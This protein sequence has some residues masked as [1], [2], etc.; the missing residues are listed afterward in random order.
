LN[1]RILPKEGVPEIVIDGPPGSQRV[2]LQPAAGESTFAA[3]IPPLPAGIYSAR[4]S[5]PVVD[6]L[7]SISFRVGSISQGLT[8]RRLDRYE[9]EQS[10]SI[11]DGTFSL[12]D[13]A[14]GM[15]DPIP[16][17]QPIPLSAREQVP[18]WNRWELLLLFA[19]C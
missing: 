16:I 11:T 8:R 19:G 9:M 13:E 10:A 17:G 18:L 1:D 15:I 7:K 12:L 2:S 3:E 5:L 4:L 6:N 14:E